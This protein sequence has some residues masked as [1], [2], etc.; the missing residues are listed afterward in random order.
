[1]QLRNIYKMDKAVIFI[2]FTNSQNQSIQNCIDYFTSCGDSFDFFLITNTDFLVDGIERSNTLFIKKIKNFND[3]IAQVFYR[4][5][6]GLHPDNFG[7]VRLKTK[8]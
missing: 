3:M 5:A 4:D 2:S 6:K 1:M 8:D 7:P